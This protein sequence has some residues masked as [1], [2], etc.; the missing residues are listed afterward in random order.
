MQRGLESLARIE[1]NQGR[2]GDEIQ[3]GLDVMGTHCMAAPREPCARGSQ[4]QSATRHQIVCYGT[5]QSNEISMRS[6][7]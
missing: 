7:R 1:G 3:H 6:T 2:V 4:A 5:V